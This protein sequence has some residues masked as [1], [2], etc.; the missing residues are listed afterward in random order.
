MD[1]IALLI[2]NIMLSFAVLGFC[3]PSPALYLPAGM[4]FI[5]FLLKISA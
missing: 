1:Y 3:I 4:L 2:L 5:A